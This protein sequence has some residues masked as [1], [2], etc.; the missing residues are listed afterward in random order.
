MELGLPCQ[1][2]LAKTLE[3]GQSSVLRNIGLQINAKMGG[4]L[5]GIKC[6]YVSVYDVFQHKFCPQQLR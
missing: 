3:R 4:E 2:I 1:V 6:P 5:W